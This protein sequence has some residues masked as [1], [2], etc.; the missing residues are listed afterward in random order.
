MNTLL[1]WAKKLIPKPVF[2]FLQP[3]YHYKMA[4]LAA[5]VYRFPS[6]K[7]K[8]VAITGTKG[9]S[10]VV[11]IVNAIL[12]EAGYKT[13]VAGTIRFKIGE[14]SER[15]LYKMTLPGRF[16]VQRFLRQAVNAG[17]DFAILEMTSEGA[18]QFRHKFISYDALIFTNL[19]PEHI[20]SH[21]SYENYLKAKLSIARELEKSAKRPRA[22]VANIDDGAGEKF[23]SVKVEKRI[24]YSI[25]NAANL[26]A[27]SDGVEFDWEGT[28]IKSRLPGKFNAYN[29]LAAASFAKAIG[30]SVEIIAA[31]IEKIVEIRGRAQ[32]IRGGQDFDAIAD[33]AHT[34]DS[35]KALYEAFQNKRKICVLGN[36]GGGRDK[37]KRPEMGR[38]ADQYCD[39]IILT[40]EDPYDEDPRQILKEMEA[41]ITKHRPEIILD[42]LEAIAVAVKKASAGDAVLITGKGTDPY[43][44]GP[45]GS[46]EPWD[47]AT[48]VR[49]ELKKI[50]R[51]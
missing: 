15:N 16:F 23:L 43:I 6:R 24:P 31:A 12:E 21:G 33:Y 28:H 22:V 1:F 11:E 40:N 46:R 14:K 49:E 39:E 34:P 45:N 3:I 38:I 30:V 35:L 51:G 44:M 9:K 4:L 20:E 36:T 18:K 13:A 32:F 7:I 10:S 47:D 25:H 50:R 37:W 17:C 27:D 26:N 29:I 2:A 42:R 41:G 19:A 48:V 8:V 5:L